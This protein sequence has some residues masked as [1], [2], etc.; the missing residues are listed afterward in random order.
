MAFFLKAPETG[1]DPSEEKTRLSRRLMVK[2][3]AERHSALIISVA[4]SGDYA[5]LSE[6]W[7]AARTASR[8]LVSLVLSSDVSLVSEFIGVLANALATGKKLPEE[9]KAKLEA[10]SDMWP[11]LWLKLYETISKSDSDAVRLVTSLVAE[12]SSYDNLL[13]KAYSSTFEKDQSL[14]A[15]CRDSMNLYLKDSRSGYLQLCTGFSD[16][17][18]PKWLS[19]FLQE[20]HVV[21]D[22]ISL[23]LSPIED[24]QNAALAIIGQAYDADLRSECLRALLEN[25]P[26]QPMA[27]LKTSVGQFNAHVVTLPEACGLA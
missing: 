16:F 26:E 15:E 10:H 9:T 18:S 25:F 8:D 13:A 6:H 5:S 23:I 24:L 1:A 20:P 12:L 11:R 2:S 4:F 7:T 17:T 3:V 21:R 27:G 14:I 22:V 19:Q